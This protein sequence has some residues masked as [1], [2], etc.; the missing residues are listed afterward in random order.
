MTAD[1]ILKIAK[2][3]IGVKEQPKIV[4][5]LSIIRNTM[6]NRCQVV[7]IHGAV[8]L[9]GGYLNK[10]ELVGYFSTVKSAPHVLQ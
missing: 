6:V 3:E 7:L 5:M 4:I 10:L 1:K 9:Y 2:A 8:Y